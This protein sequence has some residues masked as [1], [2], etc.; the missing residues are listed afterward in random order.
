MLTE[1]HFVEAW[2]PSPAEYAAYRRREHDLAKENIALLS[3]RYPSTPTVDDTLHSPETF[4]AAFAAYVVE[5][6]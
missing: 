1:L 6:R 3:S 4:D 2:E 5:K